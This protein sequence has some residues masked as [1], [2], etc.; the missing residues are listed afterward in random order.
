MPGATASVR[1]FLEQVSGKVC[2][3]DF[4][5]CY[6]PLF[7]SLGSVLR[8]ISRPDF[9][10]IG[11][12]DPRAGETLAAVHQRLCD[13]PPAMV[14]TNFT[15]AELIKLAVNTFVTTKISFANMLAELCEQLPDADVDTVTAALG[16]DARIGSRYLKGG[17]S[18][19]G[20]CFPR[21]NMALA[22][23]GRELGCQTLLAEVTDRANRQ[24]HDVIVTSVRRHVRPGM[25]VA[26]LGLAYKPDTD[27]LEE[28][29]GLHL[30]RRLAESDIKVMVHDPIP[31]AMERAR[32]LLGET[33]SYVP[34]LEECLMGADILVLAN[35]CREFHAV[36]PA[37]IPAKEPPV[38]IVDCWRMLRESFR[39]ARHVVYVAIGLGPDGSSALLARRGR[40]RVACDALSADTCL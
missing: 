26:V 8:N 31:A 17:L 40:D 19:G 28:S 12:S 32:S 15:N 35:P 1:A 4:G 36:T 34:R 7:V 10:L 5:L 38:L 20:P 18:Y 27:V 3:L 29:A 30:V 39:D 9:V 37:R 13:A 11:E 2:G 22:A 23:L 14:R 21:D 33:V 6:S 16:L 24:H 25:A